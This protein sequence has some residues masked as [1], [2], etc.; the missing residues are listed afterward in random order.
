MEVVYRVVK[1]GKESELECAIILHEFSLRDRGAQRNVRSAFRL[2]P[3]IATSCLS[4]RRPANESD[5]TVTDF[6]TYVKRVLTRSDGTDLF[7][8][9]FPCFLLGTAGC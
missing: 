6:G 2:H 5:Y 8:W 7:Y 3:R 9:L 1:K 4:S